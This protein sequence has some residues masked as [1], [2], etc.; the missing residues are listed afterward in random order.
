MGF[1][2]E[3]AVVAAGAKSHRR[4]CFKSAKVLISLKHGDWKRVLPCPERRGGIFLAGN[5]RHDWI[6]RRRSSRSFLFIG[7]GIG[8]ALYFIPT[9]VAYMRE[10]RQTL[11]FES[12]AGARGV[13]PSRRPLSQSSR[14]AAAVPGVCTA[15]DPIGVVSSNGPALALTPGPNFQVNLGRGSRPRLHAVRDANRRGGIAA[16]SCHRHEHPD[17]TLVEM[18]A[19]L[20]KRRIRTSRSA[21]WRFLDRHNI[22]FK[23]K[24]ASY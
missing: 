3:V 21:L 4:R 18:L 17:L 6:T 19:E 5:T 14:S 7:I 24:P 2:D 13:V 15:G 22:T 9:L 23:K 16:R 20:R 10:H 12:F 8:I 11:C 1:A